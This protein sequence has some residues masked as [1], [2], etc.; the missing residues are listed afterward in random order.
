MLSSVDSRGHCNDDGYLGV[1]LPVCV[2]AL[3]RTSADVR[4]L[5]ALHGL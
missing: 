4:Q 1:I 2:R 5:S 3:V